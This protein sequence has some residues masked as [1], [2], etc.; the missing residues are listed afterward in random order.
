[1]E[2]WRSWPRAGASEDWAV[3]ARRTAQPVPSSARASVERMFFS[4]ST[5][6]TRSMDRPPPLCHRDGGPARRPRRAAG[7][8]G[9]QRGR[10]HLRVELVDRLLEGDPRLAG[11]DAPLLVLATEALGLL[12]DGQGGLVVARGVERGGQVVGRVPLVLV[13]ALGVGLALL[14]V[15]ARQ[16]EGLVDLARL[17]EVVR[18]LEVAVL[19]VEEHELALLGPGHEERR[20]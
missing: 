3:A 20:D 15:L 2:G 13:A 4:S 1:G 6:S 14:V 11:V 19:V 9:L 12:V 7:S 17:H 18:R 8:V 16:R 10:G 5:T